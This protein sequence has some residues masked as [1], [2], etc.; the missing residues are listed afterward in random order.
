[1][2]ESGAAP[3]LSALVYLAGV[4]W[5]D[6]RGSD[7]HLA[8]RLSE[9]LNVLWVDPPKSWLADRR[10]GADT[11]LIPRV[12]VVAERIVRVTTSMPAAPSRPGIRIAAALHEHVWVRWALRRQGWRAAATLVSSPEP[13]SA[14]WAARPRAYY[15]TDDFVAGAD[16]I[17]MD[18]DRLR[19]AE[20]AQVAGS[21]VVMAV[22][23][24]LTQR[25]LG[26]SAR[27]LVVPNGCD[28]DHYATTNASAG[29]A[30]VRSVSPVAGVVGQL[31][32]RLDLRLL[33]AVA[34][35][36]VNLLLVGPRIAGAQDD[37][38]RALIARSNVEWVGPQRF[39]DLPSYLRIM[40]VGLTPYADSPFNRASYPLK[41]LEYLAAGRA[42]VSTDL[43][44]ARSL[45]SPDVHVADSPQGFADR[46]VEAIAAG[47]TTIDVDRRRA[48]AALHD[49]R[50]RAR[51][52]VDALR[53]AGATI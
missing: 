32:D 1:M 15:A 18:A 28:V 10:K 31:S 20:A 6:V 40:D 29:A 51:T 46:T 12:R 4:A 50:A 44:A 25:W 24:T 42:V 30:G 22:T 11:A 33:E 13:R 45:V 48:Y 34:A 7:Y 53:E 37:R 21:D 47:T 9:H 14:R 43:P 16:L 38:W 17:H 27:I 3:G 36:G 19:A 41:T 49:W 26:G 23:E 39:E 35:R 8:R 5:D 52:V 2:A